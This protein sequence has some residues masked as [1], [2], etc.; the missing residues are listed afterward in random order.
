VDYESVSGELVWADGDNTDKMFSIPLLT[1]GNVEPTE[2]LKVELSSS[3]PGSWVG[4]DAAYLT[5]ADRT[6]EQPPPAPPPTPTPPVSHSSGGG[7]VGGTLLAL[8]ALARAVSR[9]SAT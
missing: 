1:D 7:A 9:R 5:I 8:L 4:S 6:A 2:V 3:T